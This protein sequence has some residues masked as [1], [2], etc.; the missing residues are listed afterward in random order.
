M[1]EKKHALVKDLT[2]GKSIVLDP[3]WLIANDYE[4]EDFTVGE[5]ALF[6]VDKQ[7]AEIQYLEMVEDEDDLTK[8]LHREE[9]TI[10]GRDDVTVARVVQVEPELVLAIEGITIVP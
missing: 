3:A 1:D 2:I 8:Q 4:P 10:H 9:F 7:T 5:L 6:I